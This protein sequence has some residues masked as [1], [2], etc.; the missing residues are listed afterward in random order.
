MEDKQYMYVKYLDTDLYSVCSF[1]KDGNL[2][3]IEE[4]KVQRGMGHEK[5][6]EVL[7]MGMN[8]KYI[9]DFLATNNAVIVI[10]DTEIP[11]DKILVHG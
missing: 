3:I 2:Y 11:H 1:N 9:P 5:A 8:K 10:R 6:N 4:V 7:I